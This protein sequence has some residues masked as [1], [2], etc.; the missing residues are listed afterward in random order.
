MSLKKF[1]KGEIEK[2]GYPLEIEI[3]S[4]LDLAKGWEIINTDSYFD[5]D[6]GKQ[7]DIDIVANKYLPST[8]ELP[9]F[10][11]TSLIIECK[12]DDNFTWVFF[13]RPFKFE[14]HEVTGHYTDEIQMRTRNTLVDYLREIVFKDWHLHYIESKRVAVSFDEFPIKAKKGTYEA[15][16]KE[17]FTAENQLK[18]YITYMYEQECN[19]STPHADRIMFC[20]PCIVFD[21]T[22]FEAIVDKGRVELRESN[23][24]LLSTQSRATYSN[25]DLSFLIDVVTKDYFKSF[26]EEVNTD[27]K[28]LFSLVKKRKRKILR[29][30]DKLTFIS[31][32]LNKGKDRNY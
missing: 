23:H 18:K 12:K 31:S 14:E 19:E 8:E 27:V 15:K 10:I 25:W 24:I 20:F 26:L 3:S 1:L 9:V 6:E 16:R 21:G 32:T 28:S 11:E 13:T 5:K 2:T 7:R 30:L 17:V 29:E 4:V 22:M